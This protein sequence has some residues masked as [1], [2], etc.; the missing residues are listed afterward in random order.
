MTAHSRDKSKIKGN[1]EFPENYHST[2]ELNEELSLICEKYSELIS[3]H[4]LGESVEKKAIIGYIIHSNQKNLKE[5]PAALIIGG[6]HGRECI[7]SEAALYCIKYLLANYAKDKRV[8]DWIDSIVIIFI[9][10]INPDGHDMVERKNAN[11]VDLNRNYTF[12]WGVVPGCSHDRTSQIYCGPTQLSETEPQ[13]VNQMKIVDEVFLKFKNIKS[14]L[15]MHSGAEVVMFPWGWSWDPSPDEKT[16]IDICQK[17]EKLAKEM[18][19]EPFLYQREIEMYPASGTYCD[20]VYQFYK[21]I[22]FIVEIYKG[23]WAG[24]IWEFFNPPSEQV[25]SVCH[26]VLP[27]I[28]NVIDY[29]EPAP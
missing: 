4:K 14:S 11:E 26:R 22:T 8:R 2:L 27:V 13:L 1:Y 28:L 24:D 15:D 23:R 3:K 29:A 10:N 17:M 25:V 7:T 18:R 16:F 9:P 6:H 21:C 19:V 12:N 20:H 5:K